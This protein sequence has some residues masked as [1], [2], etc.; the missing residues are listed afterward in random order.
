VND[1]HGFSMS[2][3][4][5]RDVTNTVIAGLDAYSVSVTVADAGGDFPAVALPSDALRITVAVTGPAGVNVSLQGY[6]L[7]YAPNTP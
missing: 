7:R 5:I 4:T 6:R 1:Y 3:A 2:G